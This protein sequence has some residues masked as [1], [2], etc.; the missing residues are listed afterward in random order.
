MGLDLALGGMILISALRGW[1]KGLVAQAVRIAGLVACFYLADPVRDLVRPSVLGKMPAM[2]PGLLD[3]ILWW[4]A[5]V[6]SFIVLVGL[7]TLAIQLTR[8]PPPPGAPK[9]RRDD[10]FGGLLLG[11]AKGLLVTAFLAA[12]V[13]KY[14]A[15]VVRSSQ[16]AQRQTNGSYALKWTERYQPVPRIWSTPPVQS[17][18]QH[19]QRNGLGG[20][21]PPELDPQVPRQAAAEGQTEK[22]FP[23]LDMPNAEAPPS[24]QA[25]PT[26]DLDADLAHEIEGYKSELENRLPR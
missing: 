22:R 15:D 10:Q 8:T 23:R 26:L 9:S 19:I 12:A 3:R 6:V 2:E 7:T 20:A 24:D 5:A 21:M 16:W 1:M 17:F 4:V 11:A 18:V 14:G 25:A 13:E